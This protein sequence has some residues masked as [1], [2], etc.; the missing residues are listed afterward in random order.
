MTKGFNATRFVQRHTAKALRVS[1][2][3]ITLLAASL[4]T[5]PAANASTA[6]PGTGNATITKTTM[7]GATPAI[8]VGCHFIIETPAPLSAGSSSLYSVGTVDS[9]TTPPPDECHLT[10]QIEEYGIAG[11]WWSPVGKL[12]DGGWQ[13]CSANLAAVAQYNCRNLVASNQ[14]RAEASLAILYKG[15]P[16]GNLVYSNTV[17]M[18]CE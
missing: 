2:P 12:G 1:V 5:T 15:V 17:N 6:T 8:T 3:L 11:A 16:G 9:C 18:Y 4:A 14:F 7:N 13:S 10:A